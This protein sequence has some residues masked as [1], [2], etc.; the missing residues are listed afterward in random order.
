MLVVIVFYPDVCLGLSE[1]NVEHTKI[2]LAGMGKYL[3][4][5]YL[6]GIRFHY[7]KNTGLIAYDLSIVQDLKIAHF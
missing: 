2:S 7:S 1:M 3:I 5:K 4:I 6:S